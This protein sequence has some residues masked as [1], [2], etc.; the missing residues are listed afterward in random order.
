[1]IDALLGLPTGDA[2]HVRCSGFNRRE[3]LRNSDET[4]VLELPNRS[5]RAF[6]SCIS[7]L[8]NIEQRA[9]LH[10]A[11]KKLILE[12]SPKLRS[13]FDKEYEKAL[14]AK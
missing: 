5:K 4:R 12:P 14:Y 8:L 7:P 6:F 10:M 13:E 11:Q 3:N 1:M 2:M 9:I